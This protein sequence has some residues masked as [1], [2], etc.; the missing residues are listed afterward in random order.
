MKR[1]EGG[2]REGS[3]GNLGTGS[4]HWQAGSPKLSRGGQGKERRKSGI[5]QAGCMAAELV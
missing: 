3:W 4:Q 5:E 2:R 1:E